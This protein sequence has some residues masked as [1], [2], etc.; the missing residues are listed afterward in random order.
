MVAFSAPALIQHFLFYLGVL[1]LIP[2]VSGIAGFS[3]LIAYIMTAALV[4]GFTYLNAVTFLDSLKYQPVCRLLLIR[5]GI[6]A[7]LTVELLVTFVLAHWLGARCRALL[8][9]LSTGLP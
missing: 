7:L 2:F 5:S 3:R 8:R 1:A 9:W 4:C 6:T